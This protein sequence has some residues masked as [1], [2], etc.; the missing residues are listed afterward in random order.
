MPGSVTTG[1]QVLRF[2]VVGGVNTLATAIAFYLLAVVVPTRLAFTLV[3]LAGLV[4]VVAVTPR[5]VFGANAHWRRRLLLALWYLVTYVVGI[6]VITLLATEFSAPR[7]VVV[8]GTVCVT[9]PLSFIGARLLLV[10]DH[11]WPP[12]SDRPPRSGSTP[13]G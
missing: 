6:A 11:V 8:L 10:R 13:S 7:E 2:L 5:Y 12:V 1:G 9:A 3:Y 4:F